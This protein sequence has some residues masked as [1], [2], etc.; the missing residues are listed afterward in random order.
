[1]DSPV[2]PWNDRLRYLFAG[3]DTSLKTYPKTVFFN[4]LTC[5]VEKSG[6]KNKLP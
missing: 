6:R 3:R 1:M 5:I 4:K 2:K